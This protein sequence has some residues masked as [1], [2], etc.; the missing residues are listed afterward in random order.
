MKNQGKIL[1]G[2]LLLLSCLL[3]GCEDFS[4]L[5]IEV[6]EIVYEVLDSEELDSE[7]E[8]TK[9]LESETFVID[10]NQ[11]N[12]TLEETKEEMIEEVEESIL[13]KGYAYQLLPV[14]LR[15]LYHELLD[16]LE[17][18]IDEKEI[19]SLIL[20][21]IDYVFKCVL[22]DHPELFYVEGYKY[23]KHT[24]K[25]DIKRIVFSGN[26]T[27]S[28]EEIELRKSE[29]DLVIEQFLLGI[30]MEDDE[31]TKVKYTYDY[32]IN[33]SE[34]D[35]ESIE[36]QN[37]LSVFLYGKSVCQGYAKAMQF[38]LL[39]LNVEATLV[40]GKVNTG[41]RHAW[42]LVNIDGDYYY[43]DPTWGDAS[44]VFS[45]SVDNALNDKAMINY[46]YLC[47][48]TE[49]LLKT[50]Q[51]DNVVSVPNCTATEANYYEKENIY[52]EGMDSVKMEELFNKG[53]ANN[54]TNITLKCKSQSTYNEILQV[55]IEDQEIF[56][57]LEG[58]NK[59][60]TYTYNELQL[61]ISFWL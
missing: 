10:K 37:I 1:L 28:K 61:T 21:E 17:N 48:T 40:I 30:S 50:H 55:M 38:L 29:V 6:E 23:T 46:D 58:E 7:M 19:S 9:T 44:Y 52:F 27:M 25:E 13:E 53:Y 4:N 59:T 35:L 39:E 24:R 20:E 60:V 5:L 43:V 8:D 3:V 41:E 2:L 15:P 14:E 32:I 33:N 51:I 49:Q 11:E 16:I 57:Y 42:N 31:Y 54:E 22:V 34:Y 47:V 45:A 18:Q 36:N 12:H 56:S 26:Y